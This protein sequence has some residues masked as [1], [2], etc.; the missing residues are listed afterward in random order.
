MRRFKL[1]HETDRE[2][3]VRTLD[4]A[5]L[6]A[7]ALADGCACE[8]DI[9][10]YQLLQMIQDQPNW[11]DAFKDDYKLEIIEAYG[12]TILEEIDTL[13]TVK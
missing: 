8:A 12:F 1:I 7:L 9:F 5:F 3:S 13:S 10:D 11:I 6:E 2:A 4:E